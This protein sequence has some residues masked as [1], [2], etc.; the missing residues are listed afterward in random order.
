MLKVLLKIK[1]SAFGLNISAQRRNEIF[2]SAIL[3]VDKFSK[4]GDVKVL[5]IEMVKIAPVKT[6]QVNHELLLF[7]SSVGFIL[8]KFFGFSK[9]KAAVITITMQRHFA[10]MWQILEREYAKIA[11]SDCDGSPNRFD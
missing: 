2:D 4:S 8:V 7:Q 9:A 3:A 6:A 11:S 5:A 1:L 10:E